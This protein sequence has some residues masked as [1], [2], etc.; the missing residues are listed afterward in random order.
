ML[1][2]LLKKALRYFLVNTKIQPVDLVNAKTNRSAHS[3]LSSVQNPKFK[4]KKSWKTK[5]S[6]CTKAILRP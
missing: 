6:P 2:K 4:G 5:K 3:R 1:K